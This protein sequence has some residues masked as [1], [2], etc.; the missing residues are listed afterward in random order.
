MKLV[1]TIST[2]LGPS[3][4]AQLE[5]AKDDRMEKHFGKK[6]QSCLKHFT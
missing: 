4:K 2:L 6:A 5:T 1:K 3:L